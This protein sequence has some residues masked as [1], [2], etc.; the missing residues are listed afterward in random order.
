M[1]RRLTAADGG[2]VFDELLARQRRGEVEV[3]VAELDG[4]AVGRASLDF[5]TFEEPGVVE[6]RDA[7]VDAARRSRGIGTALMTHLEPIAA[8]RG[9][10]VVEL[11][12]ERTN[13]RARALYERVGYGLHEAD[14]A[15]PDEACWRMRKRLPSC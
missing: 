13:E 5:T 11:R 9:Y 4:V 14:A 2:P 6:L 15:A 3:V 1:I 12:F 7:H 10:S 8:E